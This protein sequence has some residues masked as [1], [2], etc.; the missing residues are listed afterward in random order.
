MSEHKD[1]PVLDHV[2]STEELLSLVS[3]LEENDPSSSNYKRVLI[4]PNI[5]LIKT[6][7]HVLICLLVI[8]ILGLVLYNFFENLSSVGKTRAE[9]LFRNFRAN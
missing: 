3:S 1:T 8:S 9:V 6:F 4:R 7:F 2:P 5:H